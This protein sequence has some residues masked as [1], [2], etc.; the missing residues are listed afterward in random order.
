VD[1]DVCFGQFKIDVGCGEVNVDVDSASGDFDVEFLFAGLVVAGV[2]GVASQIKFG[3]FE[4]EFRFLFASDVDVDAGQVEIDVGLGH[5]DV[6]FSF[7]KL[8][9]DVEFSLW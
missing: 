6:N 4:T 3:Q 9:I 5:I 8:N 7:G 1:V 2:A